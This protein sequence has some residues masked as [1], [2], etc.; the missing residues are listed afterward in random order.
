MLVFGC[1]TVS[2]SQSAKIEELLETHGM[3]DCNPTV[4][5]YRSGLP[6]DR[7]PDDSIEPSD[8]PELVR[9]YQSLVGGLLWLQRQT[10]PDISTVTILLSSYNHRPTASR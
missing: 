1:L 9:K 5:P 2:I 10:R 6:I 8:K 4:T 3:S 7:I